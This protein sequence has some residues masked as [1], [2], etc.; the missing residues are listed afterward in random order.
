M[1]H[2]GQNTICESEILFWH[3]PTTLQRDMTS[4]HSLFAVLELVKLLRCTRV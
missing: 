1:L 3:V 2:V 4:T